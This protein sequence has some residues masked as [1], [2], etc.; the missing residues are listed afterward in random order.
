MNANKLAAGRA[1][2]LFLSGVSVTIGRSYACDSKGIPLSRVFLFMICKIFGC[3][4]ILVYYFFSFF[5]RT[6]GLF[7]C[8]KFEDCDQSLPNDNFR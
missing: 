8:W 6:V 7:N 5:Y 1:I 4:A 3:R 2:R